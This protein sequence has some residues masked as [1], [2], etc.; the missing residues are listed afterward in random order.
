MTNKNT[1]MLDWLKTMDNDTAKLQTKTS[2]SYLRLIA[3]GHKQPSAKV[4]TVIEKA[5]GGR[6]TRRELRPKDWHEIW[7]EIVV[8]GGGQ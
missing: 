1:K 8:N 3:Y 7:P 6:I 2:F 4:A 5:T